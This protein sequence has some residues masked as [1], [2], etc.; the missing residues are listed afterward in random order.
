MS[1]A[2]K[3]RLANGDILIGAVLNM[4]NSI[5]VEMCDTPALVRIGER[6]ANLVARMLD[7]GA[8]GLI[9]PH[10]QTADEARELVSWCR[11]KPRGVRGSGLA[12]GALRHQGNEFQRRQ[13]ASADVVCIMIVEDREGARNL[14]EIMAVEGVTGIA[15]GPGDL[16]MDIGADRWDDPRVT[17]MLNELAAIVRSHKDAGLLRLCLD[18]AEIPDLINSGANMI[19]LN[20]DAHLIKAM[21]QETI[22]GMVRAV[23]AHIAK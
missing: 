4:T 22:S 8:A 19:I 15:I 2:I 5:M 7:A 21:Y 10:V 6:S 11:Y 12:R 9:F 13:Q 16:A 23:T 20:H 17:Q 14:T 18:Q 3:T 1:R